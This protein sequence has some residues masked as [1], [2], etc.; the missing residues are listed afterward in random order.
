[1]K[2]LIMVKIPV[3]GASMGKECR[4]VGMAAQV[5]QIECLFQRRSGWDRQYVRPAKST[6]CRA[7]VLRA[8]TFE[9]EATL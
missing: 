8:G 3:D 7:E 9:L 1:M 6:F 4:W 5:V 2:A